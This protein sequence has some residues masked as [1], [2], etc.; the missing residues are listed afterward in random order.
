MEYALLIACIFLL[1]GS[2]AK[3]GG[4]ITNVFCYLI[5]AILLV[6][7]WEHKIFICASIIIILI[8]LYLI[9][10][11]SEYIKYKDETPEQREERIKTN[12]KIEDWKKKNHF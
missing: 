8:T 9:L 6:F 11:I 4:C 10:L 12:K 5:L 7:M 3:L 2:T 1:S